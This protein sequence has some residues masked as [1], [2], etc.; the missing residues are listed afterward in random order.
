[1]GVYLSEPNRDK[2]INEGY[3]KGVSFCVAEMQGITYFIQAGEETCKTL[4]SAPSTLVMG[5]RSLQ[6][7]MDMEVSLNLCRSL[8]QQIRR[9]NIR[10]LTQS[11]R[12]VQKQRLPEGP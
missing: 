5:T 2:K 12:N 7:S 8:S 9:K 3:K 1:M 11:P 4:T 6:S 10:R